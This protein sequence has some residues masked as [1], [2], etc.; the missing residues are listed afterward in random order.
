M[1]GDIPPAFGHEFSVMHTR[2]HVPAHLAYLGDDGVRW[3]RRCVDGHGDMPHFFT[4]YG[5]TGLHVLTDAAHAKCRVKD[6]AW[7][8]K[9]RPHYRDR[10]AHHCQVLASAGAGTGGAVGTV[11]LDF[12]GEVL[13][14]RARLD[15]FADELT[16]L[17][18][19]V[20]AHIA[21]PD[22]NVPIR[23]GEALPAGREGSEALG[24][25][26][27]EGFDRYALAECLAEVRDKLVSGRVASRVRSWAHYAHAYRLDYEEIEH[28]KHFRNDDQLISE[29]FGRN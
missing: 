23:V 21:A 29:K 25:L 1:W 15:A 17:A 27:I 16:R 12:A 7:F 11:L 9:M 8:M 28:T 24:V 19:V 4:F 26:I 10:I 5:L 18:P 14:D 22:W 13:C 6:S 20:S 3:A 2:D